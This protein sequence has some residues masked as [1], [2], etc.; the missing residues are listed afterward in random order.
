MRKVKFKAGD[1]VIVRAKIDYLA[2]DGTIDLEIETDAGL[3]TVFGVSFEDV[4]KV[5]KED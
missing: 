1:E 4:G 3:H 5:V 2:S